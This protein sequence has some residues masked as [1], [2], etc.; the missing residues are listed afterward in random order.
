MLSSFRRRGHLLSSHPALSSSTST[1]AS[2]SAAR[3]TK[4]TVL[5]A[6]AGPVGLTLSALLSRYGVPNLVFEKSPTLSLHPQAHFINC[7]TM[8]LFR[9]AFHPSLFQRINN[10]VPPLRLWRH[11]IYATSV[12]N[13]TEIGRVDHFSPTSA[14]ASANTSPAPHVLLN[15]QSPACVAHL[16]QSRLMPLLYDEVM[17]AAKKRKEIRFN[18]SNYQQVV[19]FGHEVTKFQSHEPGEGQGVQVIVQDKA[20]GHTR[21]FEGSYLIVANG[22]SSCLRQQAQIDMQGECGIQH[23]VNIHFSSR[24]L[25]KATEHRPAMLYFLFNA[26]VICVLVAHHF[27]TGEFV[28]Q[29]PFFPPVQSPDDFD[30]ATVKTLLDAAIGR[31]LPDL[32]VHSVQ[33]WTMDCQVAERYRSGRILL[34]GDAAHRFPP[35]GGFGMNTGI[36]DAHNLAWKLALVLNGHVNETFLD[37]YETERR[38]VAE[39]N[40]NLSMR[41]YTRSLR[42]PRALGLDAEEA[43]SLSQ[44]AAAIPMPAPKGFLTSLLALGRRPLRSLEEAGQPYGAACLA[45][46]RK[47]L[48]DGAGLPLLFPQDDLGF[49]YPPRGHLIGEDK[50][51]SLALIRVGCRLPHIWLQCVHPETGAHLGKVSTT[52]LADQVHVALTNLDLPCFCNTPFAILLTSSVMHKAVGPVA[53]LRWREGEMSLFHVRIS[54]TSPN[55]ILSSCTTETTLAEFSLE[56][57]EALCQHIFGSKS[58]LQLEDKEG[59]WERR[60]SYL[61]AGVLLR[62]DGHIWAILKSTGELESCFQE[63]FQIVW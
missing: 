55:S 25:A 2:T 6:G 54:S 30:A 7:R 5:I 58:H 31:T 22:A 41:N 38:P 53:Q 44:T 32:T 34:A 24:A 19:H 49:Q 35:A 51:K 10:C 15:E 42:M 1:W 52:D 50:Y 57:M 60:M 43:K 13:G 63:E 9:H 47:I 26:Q 14:L 12:L 62:P 37:T 56:S 3:T 11:F 33:P 27:P 61:G 8:E 36:Q 21:V 29:V 23:L 18:G 20:S 4:K 39:H 16:S 28:A 48:Q 17:A 46:A 59:E 45:K 40:A